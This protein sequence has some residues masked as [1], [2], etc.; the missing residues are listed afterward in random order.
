MRVRAVTFVLTVLG[1]G[2]VGFG[3]DAPGSLVG[4]ALAASDST[5]D[6]E[7]FLRDNQQRLEQFG[8]E[9]DRLG[10]EAERKGAET[11]R[12]MRKSLERALDDV[13]KHLEALRAAGI[14]GW[15]EALDA[16]QK[17][18]RDYERRRADSDITDI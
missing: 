18:L 5:T 2:I 15:K 14:A 13:K 10:R 16:Y 9:L 6:R 1:A 12:D 4:S 17:S 7:R 3:G 11:G 8:R